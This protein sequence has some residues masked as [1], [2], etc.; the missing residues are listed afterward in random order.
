[1][2][3]CDNAVSIITYTNYRIY[4]NLLAQTLFSLFSESL[5]LLES[6]CVVNIYI[7]YGNIHIVNPQALLCSNTKDT[8]FIVVMFCKVI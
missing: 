4:I 2:E 8:I 1:M 6:L 5:S 7:F 3:N